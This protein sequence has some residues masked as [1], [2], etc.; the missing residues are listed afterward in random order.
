MPSQPKIREMLP[1]DLDF[2]DRVRE[3][4][5]W[6]QTLADWRRLVEFEPN[7]CFVA[8]VGGELAGT[9]TTTTFG[10]DLGW[11]GMMLVHPDFRRKGVATALMERAM[12]YL[13]GRV[14]CIKL[15][16]T[17]EGQPVYEKLGFRAEF[18]LGRWKRSG[19]A[20]A[21]SENPGRLAPMPFDRPAFGADRRIWLEN[22]GL[23]AKIVRVLRDGQAEPKAFGI[24]REGIRADYLGPVVGRD[25]ASG[26]AL[27][28]KLLP[29]LTGE[30][31]W[32]ILEPNK[33]A[34]A[35]AEES[36]FVQI[37]PLLRMWAGRELVAGNPE[38][39]FAI[40]DPGTG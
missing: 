2:A 21:K 20:P 33:V 34:T 5:G 37:R 14:R 25:S 29:L 9:V 36:G 24:I 13:S 1:R 3:I 28:A 31:F 35:L 11:I 6:N 15:D 26:E 38:L 30:A 7:G 17:P 39:Q 4:A 18:G 10:A 16:A 22:L 19:S 32:D 40:G 27:T 8:E 23:D 12:G